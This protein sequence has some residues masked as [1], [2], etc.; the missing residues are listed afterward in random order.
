METLNYARIVVEPGLGDWHFALGQLH[1]HFV[2]ADFAA[3]LE[4]VNRTGALAEEQDHH[5]DIDLRYKHVLIRLTSHDAGGVTERDLKL[6]RGISAAAAELGISSRLPE[7]A[8]EVGIDTAA[9]ALIAPFWLA[10]LD[11]Y[12]VERDEAGVPADLVDPTGVRPTIWFQ[13]M[14]P[15]RTERSR[16]HFDVWVAPEVALDRVRA[17]V[18]AGG[19]LVRD[20]HA[21]S[22]WVLA[23][24]EGNEVCICTADRSES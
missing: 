15:P 13:H 11:G 21:P 20:D 22:F 5:P 7:I 19:E 23:D 2:P 10:V 4:L 14:D 12:K 18:E 16:F 9:P 3:G 8:I 24:P 1:A 6:A 17:A